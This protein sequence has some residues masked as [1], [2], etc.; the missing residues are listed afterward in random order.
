MGLSHSL[1]S[2]R[3]HGR[4]YDVKRDMRT[5]FEIDLSFVNRCPFWALGTEC[6]SNPRPSKG[7]DCDDLLPRP[8]IRPG[9]AN[10]KGGRN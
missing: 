10:R 4:M 2:M 3:L 9:S 6:P 5:S 7:E 1:E 8:M